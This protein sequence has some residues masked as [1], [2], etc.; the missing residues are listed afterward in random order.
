[1]VSAA[2]EKEILRKQFKIEEYDGSGVKGDPIV[3]ETS[4]DF[5]KYRRQNFESKRY[6]MVKKLEFPYEEGELVLELY[7]NITFK[8][9]RFVYFSIISCSDVIIENCIFE[10]GLYVIDVTE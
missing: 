6:I 1:M 10:K 3:I 4:E 9:C 5:F 7:H 2:S 8:N